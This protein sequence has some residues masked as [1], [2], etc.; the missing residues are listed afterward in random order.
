VVDDAA[1][2]SLSPASGS[3][4]GDDVEN[5]TVSVD[6]SEISA[7]SY[8]TAITISASGATNTPQ[9]VPL[10]LTITLPTPA[11]HEKRAYQY[12][13]EVMDK[14]HNS[15]DVYTDQDA[16]GN[17]FIPSGWMGDWEDI[18]TYDGNFCGDDRISPYDGRS[19]IKTGC[20]AQGSQGS[21]WAG[22]Y[23]QYPE[24]NWGDKEG[25]YDLTGATEM[26]FRARGD[27][28]GEKVEFKMGGIN[29]PP[30][31]DKTNIYEDSCIA[32]STGVVTLTDEW[33]QYT[34]DLITSEHFSVY[35]DKDAGGNNRFIPSGWMGDTEDITFDDS[36]RIDPRSGS[37]C[38]KITY[39]PKG[40]QKWA[41]IYWLSKENNWG[42]HCGYDLT[43]ATKLTFWARGENGGEQ[44]EFKIGGVLGNC[45]DSI[46]PAKSTGGVT[47]KKEWQ[48]FTIPL[49][50][51]D[52]SNIVGGFCWVAKKDNNP[53]GCTIYLDEITFDKVINKDLSHTIGGF[54]WV[55]S[56]SDNPEGCTFYLDN[57][58]YDKKRLEQLRFLESYESTCAPE[59]VS[60]RNSAHIYDNALALLAFMDRGGEEDW[61]RARILADSFVYCQK[62]D[63]YYSDKPHDRRLRNAY[64]SGDL[65]DKITKKARLPGWWD[66]EQKKWLEDK[67]HVSSYT[68]NL[69]WVMI[70][71]LKYYEVK[72]GSDYLMAAEDLA[73]WIYGNCKDDRGD[74]GYTGGFLGWEP[75]PE[76]PGGQKKIKWKSTEHNLDIYVAFTKLY[77]VTGNSTWMDRA[78][79]AKAFVEAMWNEEEG[80]FWIGTSDNG[81]TI[82]KDVV[83][84]DVQTWGL[85]ALGNVKGYNHGVSWVEEYCKVDPCPVCGDYKGFDFSFDFT[86]DRNNRDGVWWE[87]TAHMC[88][89]FR[90]KDEIEKSNEFIN[91]LR[92]AQLSANRNN[93]K[94]IVAACHDGLTTGLTIPCDDPGHSDEQCPWYYYNRLHV[95]ATAWYIFAERNYNPLQC[96]FPLLG[97]INGNGSVGLEDASLALQVCTGITP[98]STIHREADVNGDGRIGLEDVIY[99]L[100]KVAELR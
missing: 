93:G 37:S 71:L 26:T 22:I 65:A 33:M 30:Y 27:K 70:A 68:G 92:K 75:T 5:V 90:I 64:Q 31:H 51:E 43:G 41:G 8:Q 14:Y 95:G 94:G 38:T 19:C 23:W 52:L 1:W 13:Q 2:L 61:Q 25:H 54:C 77:E 81:V 72:G 79:H 60:I 46:Q 29:T 47:L 11:D 39:S 84:E 21:D 66:Y 100:Q 97:D 98:S 18:I 88:I 86:D 10:T 76:N 74:G 3:S 15:F 50:G 45:P 28:G 9:I 58:Q 4:I 6:I 57:M 32:L 7:G 16:G 89:A 87:G 63:R 91:Q 73:K 83:P 99:M 24:N 44:V 67:Y 17:H 36:H 48:E 56:R 40:P 35:T 12:L 42:Y 49:E 34:I 80:H 78:K 96:A 85:M 53:S 20:S 82:N 59:D 69:A 62:H 55:A